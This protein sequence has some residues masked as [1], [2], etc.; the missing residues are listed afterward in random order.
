MN[1]VQIKIC[2]MKKLFLYMAILFTLNSCT[3]DITPDITSTQ[4]VINLEVGDKYQGGIILYILF[5]K[6]SGFD[7]KIQHGIIVSEK[8]LS[9]GAQWG[10][11]DKPFF[12]TENTKIGSGKE[13]TIKI[14]SDCATL[15]IA[16]RLCADLV[17]NGYSD[18]YLPSKDEL[19]MII[20][21]R[22]RLPGIPF[23]TF[24]SSSSGPPSTIS[25]YPSP[26]SV[27][28]F[29]QAFNDYGIKTESKDK[30]LAVRAVRYF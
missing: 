10:C 21:Q 6:D 20:L 13:N 16:A 27:A 2:N 14:I 29:G 12:G 3:K 26:S 18:W 8:N 30:P 23:N 19:G 7:S 11:R 15:D 22:S 1:V 17:E 5:Q 9:L 28:Y 24:W 4:K 25:Y